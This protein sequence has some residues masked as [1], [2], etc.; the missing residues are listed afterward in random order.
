MILWDSEKKPRGTP[1]IAFGHVVRS[2]E[3]TTEPLS[4]VSAL[5]RVE[6]NFYRTFVLVLLIERLSS[7]AYTAIIALSSILVGSDFI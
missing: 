7:L 3:K 1:S 4:D 5:S 6:D 2:P